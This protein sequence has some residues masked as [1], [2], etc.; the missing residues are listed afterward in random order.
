LILDNVAERHTLHAT[1]AEL[2]RRIKDL[3]ERRGVPAEQL[4]ASLEKG[5]RLRDVER[6]ITEEKVFAYLVSQSTVEQT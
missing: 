5:K 3:A 2:D 4:Y 6:S 1:E